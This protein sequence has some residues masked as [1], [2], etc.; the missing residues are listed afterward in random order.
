MEPIASFKTAT[1]PHDCSGNITYWRSL[2]AH[3]IPFSVAQQVSL[4]KIQL[5]LLSV[6]TI[7]FSG[8]K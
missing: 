2:S 3:T 8:A 6:H 7:P 4:I 1:M 5:H